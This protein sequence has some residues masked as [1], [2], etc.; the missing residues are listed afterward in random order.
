M[1]SRFVVAEIAIKFRSGAQDVRSHQTCL[2]LIG[3]QSLSFSLV[4]WKESSDGWSSIADGATGLFV[5]QENRLFD[6]SVFCE[7][8]KTGRCLLETV[9]LQTIGPWNTEP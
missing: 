8:R 3:D 2:S 4:E 6:G 7:Y 5:G 9:I 1:T